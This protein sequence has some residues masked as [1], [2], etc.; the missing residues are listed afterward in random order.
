VHGLDALTGE[1]R[2]ETATRG[3][4]VGSAVA[5]GDRF[6][7]GSTDGGLYLVAADGHIVQ[8]S[9]LAAAGV[10]SSAALGADPTA[11]IGSSEGLHALRLRA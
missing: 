7:V 6:L 1:P 2:F 8:R 10:Q 4:I 5:V 11:F 9:L 3:P